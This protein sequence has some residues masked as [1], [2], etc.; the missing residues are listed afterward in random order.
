MSK[1]LLPLA[2]IVDGQ[3]EENIVTKVV[4]SRWHTEGEYTIC[5]EKELCKLYDVPYCIMT[6]SGT[7]ANYLALASLNLPKNSIVLSSACGFASTLSPIIHLGYTPY[8]VDFSIN[9]LNISLYEIEE[10]LKKNIKIN[11][12]LIAHNL[13]VSLDM[14]FLMFLKQKHNFQLI[15]DCCESTGV[16]FK[17]KMIGS[18]GELG[19]LSFFPS[20]ICNALGGGGAILL[21]D[22]RLDHKIR[23]LKSWG[24]ENVNI[25]EYYTAFTTTIDDIPYDTGYSYPTIGHNMRITDAQSAYLLEQ[26]KRLPDFTKKRYDNYMCLLKGLQG[27][28][29]DFMTYPNDCKPVFFGFPMVLQQDNLRDKLV[30]HLEQNGIKCRLFFGGNLLRQDGFKNIHWLPKNRQ[31]PIADHLMKNAFFCGCWPGLTLE[32]MD[33]VAQVIKDFFKKD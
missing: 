5:V 6:N 17:D 23:S 11:A 33:Y 32:D 12:I 22:K 25:G 27:L 20:H 29:I 16:L 19:T 4:R 10:A 7:S 9:T 3:E 24:K 30:N 26:L 31:F 14:D 8:L 28:P 13:G 21:K 15:E 18:F 1:K 2:G